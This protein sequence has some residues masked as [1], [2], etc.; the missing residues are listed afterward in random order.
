MV[1]KVFRL[2]KDTTCDASFTIGQTIDFKS[3]KFLGYQ[4]DNFDGSQQD[5]YTNMV[6]QDIPIPVYLKM[7]ILNNQNVAFYQ[8]MNN[9][10]DT[11]YSL[12]EHTIHNSIPL[13]VQLDTS[14]QKMNLTLIN[15]PTTLFASDTI[16]ISLLLIN[17]G[18]AYTIT[19]N[20]AFGEDVMTNDAGETMPVDHGVSLFF[21]FETDSKQ[22]QGDYTISDAVRT[23]GQSPDAWVDPAGGAD[24]EGDP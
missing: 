23:D 18:H 21:D 19:N 11:N 3:M 2:N 13:G 12:S 15:N 8:G 20:M 5:L 7:S 6:E 17:Q 4:W 24:E 16:T 10:A 1:L 22:L 9:S 14:F